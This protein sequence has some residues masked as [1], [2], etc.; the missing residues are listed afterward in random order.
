VSKPSDDNAALVKGERGVNGCG[1]SQNGAA[2][3]EEDSTLKRDYFTKNPEGILYISNRM[4]AWIQCPWCFCCFETFVCGV[5]FVFFRLDGCGKGGG[6]QAKKKA[7]VQPP[8][9]SGFGKEWGN[10]GQEK[11]LEEKQ[12][13]V[14]VV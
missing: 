13:A 8:P 7:T 9:K 2:R 11:Y 4:Q 14:A 10:S 5:G 12:P 3:N 1:R 6:G